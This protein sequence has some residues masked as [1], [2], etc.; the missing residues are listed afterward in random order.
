MKLKINYQHSDIQKWIT[1]EIRKSLKSK[2][3]IL[4]YHIS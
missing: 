3:H 1:S 4:T 2:S